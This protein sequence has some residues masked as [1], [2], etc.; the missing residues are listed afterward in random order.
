MENTLKNLYFLTIDQLKL[1]LLSAINNLYNNRD[2][3]NKLN[4]FPVADNDTGTNMYLTLSS[5]LEIINFNQKESIFNFG[6]RFCKQLMFNSQGNSGTILCQIFKGFFSIFEKETEKI[7]IIDFKKAIK[8]AYQWSINAVLMPVEGTILTVLH[9][10]SLKLNLFESNNFFDLIIFFNDEL[11]KAVQK[12]KEQLTILKKNDV[13]DSG[14]LGLLIIFQGFKYFLIKNKIIEKKTNLKLIKKKENNSSLDNFGYCCEYL[15]KL[16]FKEIEI[17]EKEIKDYLKKSNAESIIF[18]KEEKNYIKIHFHISEFEKI[19]FYLKNSQNWEFLKFKNEKII[20]HSKRVEKNFNFL[21]LLKKS[22]FKNFLSKKF[23][24][25]YFLENLNKENVF[26]EINKFLKKRKEKN[27]YIFNEYQD[28]IHI[29]NEYQIKFNQ[30]NKNKKINFININNIGEIINSLA[31]FN[32]S[33]SIEKNL[34]SMQQAIKKSNFGN[35]YLMKKKNSFPNSGKE[36]IFEV[37]F[38]NKL[39]EVFE[40]QTNTLYF[41]FKKIIS[42]TSKLVTIFVYNN[43]LSYS[44]TF[45]EIIEK[46]KLILKKIYKLN[47]KIVNYNH[48]NNDNDSYQ[49]K[50]G[51]FFLTN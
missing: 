25:K 40:T 36:F 50:V 47:Y 5:T 10:A 41:L 34:I 7:S 14:A 42:N 35:I 45:K 20:K 49:E 18:L 29:L 4:F 32:K 33:M 1:S 3:I 28:F 31:F 23:K 19:D 37:S 22:F 38:N 27:I 2:Y 26:E 30:Q 11:E 46:S 17:L 6:K 39:K 15:I 8:V 9:H 24:I 21:V 51:L 16:K 12:T 13:F 48:K 43:N 44:K